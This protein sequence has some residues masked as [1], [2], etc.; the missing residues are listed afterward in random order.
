MNIGA[1]NGIRTRDYGLGSRNVASTLYPHWYWY[2]NWNQG[3]RFWVQLSSFGKVPFILPPIEAEDFWHFCHKGDNTRC[4][5]SC[6]LFA[7]MSYVHSWLVVSGAPGGTWTRTACATAPSRRR[8]CL[9]HHR[10]D[11]FSRYVTSTVCWV[12][13]IVLRRELDLT[14]T[15]F[16]VSAYSE[17]RKFYCMERITGFEPV[18]TALESCSVTS[19]L[20]PHHD[21]FLIQLWKSRCFVVLLFASFFS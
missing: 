19:T 1:D 12:Y 15:V 14:D 6:L 2:L 7:F 3:L 21:I 18:M 13:L 4:D 10:R 20:Y 5:F 9:F 8:V 16:S 17:T 11:N